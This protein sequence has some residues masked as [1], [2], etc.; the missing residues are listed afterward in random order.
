[1][2]PWGGC[3]ENVRLQLDDYHLKTHM[4]AIDM[5]GCDVVLGVEW[6]HTLGLVTMDSKELYLIFTQTLILTC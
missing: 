5:G 3:Y 6:L 2:I 4:F 1:M